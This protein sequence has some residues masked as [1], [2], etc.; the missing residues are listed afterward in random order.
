MTTHHFQPSVYHTAIGAYEPALRIASGDT[1]ET[2]TVDSGGLD[3]DGNQATPGGNPQTGPFYVEGAAPGDVLAVRFDKIVPNRPWG[4]TS[5][6]VAAHVVDPGFVGQLPRERGRGHWEVDTASWTATLA[7]PETALGR[8]TIPLDPMIGCFG[9]APPRGQAISC[10]TSGTHGGNMDYRGFRQGVTVYFP[11]FVEGALFHLG[12]GHATQGD[13]EITGTGTEISMDVTFTTWIHRKGQPITWP[14]AEDEQ[15][16][17]TVGNARPLDQAVQHATTELLKWLDEDYGL[18][19]R[20]GSLLVGQCLRYDVGN[21][22]DPA[23][24]MVAKLEKSLLA[25]YRKAD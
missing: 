3:K 24:T 9:V 22:F 21:V 1:V 14:R 19:Y 17:M 20:A 11:V 16:I 6:L 7:E 18:D 23:Y 4:R 12:D 5:A 15:F 25:P 13:G 10:A 8:F 2:S